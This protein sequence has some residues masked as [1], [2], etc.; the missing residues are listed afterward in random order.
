MIQLKKFFLQGTTEELITAILVV[1]EGIYDAES[2]KKIQKVCL[3]PDESRVFEDFTGDID[4]LD[5]MSKFFAL[6]VKVKRYRIR[7]SS[8]IFKEEFTS[9]LDF[10]RTNLNK[11]LKAAMN[12]MANKHLTSFLFSIQS[13]NGEMNR[14]LARGNARGIKL[15]SAIELKSQKSSDTSTDVMKYLV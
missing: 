4:K 11:L 12:L 7:L 2:C 5:A 14:G 15:Q 3:N 9:L 1:N 13:L 6:I 8:I 10:H